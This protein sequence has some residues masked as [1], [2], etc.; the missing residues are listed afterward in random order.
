MEKKAKNPELVA[1]LLRVAQFKFKM[2][3]FIIE[4]DLLGKEDTAIRKRLNKIF[5][6]LDV[7]E[8]EKTKGKIKITEGQSTRLY[9]LIKKLMDENYALGK[10]TKAFAALRDKFFETKAHWEFSENPDETDIHNKIALYENK[11]VIKLEDD[12]NILIKIKNELK[13]TIKLLEKLCTEL[14]G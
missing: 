7:S 2:D 5:S 3:D 1:Y 10:N 12:L 6:N 8:K 9:D 13:E 11:F 14:K 4:I